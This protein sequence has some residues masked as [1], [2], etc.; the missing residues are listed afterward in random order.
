MSVLRL[1]WRRMTSDTTDP[2][3]WI[4]YGLTYTAILA[5]MFTAG[6]AAMAIVG[7]SPDAPANSSR[8]RP[9]QRQTLA[10]QDDATGEA[11]RDLQ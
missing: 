6:N 10:R 11:A 2:N 5:T 1:W 8:R 9:M 7:A 3:R 4:F